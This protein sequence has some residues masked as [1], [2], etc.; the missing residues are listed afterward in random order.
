MA[1]G[2][3]RSASALA[4]MT[5]SLN[6]GAGWSPAAALS[7]L[8]S[9]TASSMSTSTV[10][11]KSGAVA[12]DSAIRRA[13]VFCSRVRSC[14]V[15]SPRPACLS[16]EMT[17]AGTSCFG[18]SSG[19]AAGAAA[20]SS[21]A[22]AASC[23]GGASASAVAAPPLAAAS[24]SAFTIRPPGP[25]PFSSP[26]ST[27]ISRAIRLATGEALMRSPPPLPEGASACAGAG[28]GASSRLPLPEVSSSGSASCCSA[29]GSSSSAG[30]SASSGSSSPPDG[31]DPSP[32]RAIGSPTG[33]VSPSF[34]TIVSVPSESA[35]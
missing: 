33:S 4:L 23:F 2:K 15:V 35:S 31:S 17:G 5:K 11:T 34:A 21:C 19:S 26:S 13:T 10:R 3:S 32:S 6:E 1:R 22:G 9:A 28:S 20:S 24:T 30:A 25:E 29:W 16:P 18:A 7:C 12:F 27:P 14:S 8:R